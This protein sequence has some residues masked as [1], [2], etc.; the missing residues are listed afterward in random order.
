MNRIALNT[1]EIA[2]AADGAAP[3]WVE[4]IPAADADGIVA[5]RDGR[6]WRFDAPA[7][8]SILSAHAGL[9][10]DVPVDWEHATQHRA[11]EGGEAPAAGW[12]NQLE[13]RDGALWGQ[14]EWTERAAQQIGSREYRYLSPVFDYDTTTRRIAQLVSVGL[15]NLP[16]LRLTALNQRQEPMMRSD[17]LT[18]AIVSALGLKA[19]ASDDDVATALNSLKQTADTAQAL[20]SQQ[21]SLERFVPRADYDAALNRAETAEATIKQQAEAAHAA[22]VETAVN[23]AVAAGKIVPANRDYYKQSCNTPEGLARFREF[24]ERAPVIAA[25]SG[26]DD[27]PAPS[28]QAMNA[29]QLADKARAYQ[30]QQRQQGIDISISAAVRH[31]QQEGNA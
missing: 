30:A 14:V 16:N 4:L 19:D 3:Q 26:L 13:I 27:K 8:Q 24:V 12:V 17:A 9:G 1:T 11:S 20:N 5:G 29:Q 7:H 28:G 2:L 6:A 31:V 25:P 15:T 23:D 18:A 22:A 10:M 21:P